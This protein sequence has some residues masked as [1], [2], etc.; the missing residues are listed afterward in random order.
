M[1]KRK[2]RLNFNYSA[3][4]VNSSFQI[5]IFFLT[6]ILRHKPIVIL[7]AMSYCAS[8]AIILWGNKVWQMQLM[9][10]IFGFYVIHLIVALMQFYNIFLRDFL[11]NRILKCL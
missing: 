6:D 10:I 9:E 2:N 7:E 1:V 11:N 3:V 8:H 5:P 4:Q